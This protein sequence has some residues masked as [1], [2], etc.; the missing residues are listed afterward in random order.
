ME[1]QKVPGKI[2]LWLCPVFKEVM[3]V[4]NNC[5]SRI[6]KTSE[7]SEIQICVPSLEKE[8]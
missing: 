3:E 2:L 1:P 8:T 4:H 5:T 6:I 7:T